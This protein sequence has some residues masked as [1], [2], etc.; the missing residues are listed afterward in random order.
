MSTPL[1]KLEPLD[2]FLKLILWT[3]QLKDERPVSAIIIGP[4][5]GGKTS[6]LEKV[7]CNV[8]IFVGDLTARTMKVQILPKPE[9]THILLGDL[10]SLFGHK[11]S[12][13]DLSQQIIAKL[14]GE[15]LTEDPW[16]GDTLKEPRSVG[17]I[18]AIPPEDFNSKRKQIEKGGWSS[19]F[20]ILKYRY[21][22]LTR[23]K[24][25]TFLQHNGYGKVSKEK[26][27]VFQVK[28]GK[29]I[30]KI[31]SSIALKINTLADGLK[32]DPL[33]FRAHRH[34]RALVKASALSRGSLVCSTKDFT[35]IESL[36]NFFSEE[37][38][39]V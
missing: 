2:R 18:T 29:K 32:H 25:H 19:R 8:A 24:V 5:G 10:L 14:T 34:L 27:L 21:S 12:T 3:G 36:R 6:S 31:P 38:E 39:A 20:L 22:S 37:G 1:I 17:L 30:V 16:T 9:A 35:A 26:P 33:G 15:S 23:S 28:G 7:Q 11:K 4:K 13:V